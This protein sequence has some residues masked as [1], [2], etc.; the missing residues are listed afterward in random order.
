MW[1]NC[2][3]T[4]KCITF[5]RLAKISHAAYQ[6]NS[7]VLESDVLLLDFGFG[8]LVFILQL[9]VKKL[10]FAD[11]SKILHPVQGQQGKLNQKSMS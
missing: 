9:F 2:V 3:V 11:H 4:G 5:L 6:M 7:L 10:L 1:Q 8:L